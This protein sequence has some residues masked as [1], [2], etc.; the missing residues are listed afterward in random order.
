M[1]RCRSLAPVTLSGSVILLS[2]LQ[3]SPTS[4]TVLPVGALWNNGGVLC[5]VQ[6]LILLFA[7]FLIAAGPTGPTFDSLTVIGA[8]SLDNG[9]ITPSAHYDAT[10]CTSNGCPGTGTACVWDGA[11]DVPAC[12]S[13]RRYRRLP[14]VGVEAS[15]FP[16]RLAFNHSIQHYR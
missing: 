10:A 11:H 2:N 16:Y 15:S 12:A 3:T 14:Q 7:G 1:V 8:S 4:P 6:L 13:R 5:I 9:T